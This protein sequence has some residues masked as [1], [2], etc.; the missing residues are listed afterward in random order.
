M[1]IRSDF[2]IRMLG[3]RAGEGTKIS[4]QSAR[5]L[6][7]GN[8]IIGADCIINN[9]F[10]FDRKDAKIT[11]GNR[12]FIGKSHLVCAFGITIDDDV[13]IS[14]G[15]TIVD[16]NSHALDAD[17]RNQDIA[18]WH[19]GQKNWTGIQIAPVR[20]ERR[21]WIGFNAIILKGVTIGEGSIVGAG[22]IVTKNVAPYTVVAGNP[23]REIRKVESAS[24]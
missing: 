10:S 2:V 20:I 22:S 13:I 16:H 1:L 8:A 11:I 9:R 5:S 14:W 6:L 18:N 15:V 24:D 17:L 23:A 12:C 4:L 7:R 19:R 3:V 21:A